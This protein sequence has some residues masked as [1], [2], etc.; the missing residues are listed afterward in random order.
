MYGY[1]WANIVIKTLQEISKMPLYVTTN[2]AIK[3]NWQGLIKL[4]NVNGNNDFEN[5]HD[6]TS[7]STM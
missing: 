2:V 4:A 7:N 6:F 1:V 3:P 5:G